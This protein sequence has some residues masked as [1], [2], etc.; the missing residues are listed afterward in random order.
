M[1]WAANVNVPEPSVC[2]LAS[3]NV[4][5]TA[6]AVL[7]LLCRIWPPTVLYS[8]LKLTP[9]VRWTTMVTVSEL[10]PVVVSL[11]SS[12]LN[13]GL[14]EATTGVADSEPPLGVGVGVGVGVAVGVGVGVGVGVT[15]GVLVGDID[16]VGVG[17]ANIAT[18]ALNP[19]PNAVGVPL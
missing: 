15:V 13:Q 18:W 14:L 8:P 5:V 17:L 3:V 12:S 4:Q 6:E 1:V 2:P 9:V 7:L 10:R 11:T 19:A 16:G